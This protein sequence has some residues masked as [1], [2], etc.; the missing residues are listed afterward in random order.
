MLFVR[1]RVVSIVSVVLFFIRLPTWARLSDRLAKIG[2]RFNFL[3]RCLKNN[4]TPNTNRNINL[5]L[6]SN[7]KYTFNDNIP[8]N[9]PK[10]KF[11]LSLNRN[12]CLKLD[13]Y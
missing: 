8:G 1:I 13:D 10:K 7:N 5:Y 4:I 6:S 11:K 2:G 3:K 12:K 9:R